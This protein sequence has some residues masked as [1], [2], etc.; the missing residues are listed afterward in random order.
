MGTNDKR[1][2][3]RQHRRGVR[4][5]LRYRLKNYKYTAEEAIPKEERMILTQNEARRSIQKMN[6]PDSILNKPFQQLNN[7]EIQILSA[8]LR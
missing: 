3:N 8:A 7:T 1:G 4:Q 2:F 5:E 6:I